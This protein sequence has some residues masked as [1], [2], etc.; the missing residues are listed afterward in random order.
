MKHVLGVH[1]KLVHAFF[2]FC[3]HTDYMAIVFA[4]QSASGRVSLGAIGGEKPAPKVQVLR[5]ITPALRGLCGG[6]AAMPYSVCVC[7]CV[8]VYVFGSDIHTY[9]HKL[10][11]RGRV[12]LG[13]QVRPTLGGP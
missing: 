7:V 5:R 2:G 13:A 8:C 3:T 12:S 11:S 6:F 10:Y 1:V 9:L 4:K